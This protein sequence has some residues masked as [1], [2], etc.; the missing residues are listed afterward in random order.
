[1]QNAVTPSF[2]GGLYSAL[3]KEK[4]E[5][6]LL[7]IV[8]C[9][10]MHPLQCKLEKASLQDLKPE[11][12]SFV[13]SNGLAVRNPRQAKERWTASP[14]GARLEP[15]PKGPG[16]R[17]VPDPNHYRFKWGDYAA[18]SYV[19]GDEKVCRDIILNGKVVSVTASL[20]DALRTLGGDD[21]FRSG[22]KLSVD[23]LCINQI[24]DQERAHQVQ[25]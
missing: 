8:L 23:A 15:P 3:D 11:Y 10:P 14:C 25:K 6:R 18:L 9:R 13:L 20:E 1:M 22:Y 17:S 7:T 19:W 21:S 24:D 4:D 12:T 16:V 2:E 5:I